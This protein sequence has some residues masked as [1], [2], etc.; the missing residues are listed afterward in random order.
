MKCGLI[1]ICSF[2][3]TCICCP[4]DMEITFLNKFCE[5]G[6]LKSLL[7]A[8]R[9]PSTIIPFV[10]QLRAY[11]N[12]IPFNPVTNHRQ[13]DASLDDQILE[14]L[15]H[16]MNRSFSIEHR[17]W[18][19]SHE[20][21]R[22]EVTDRVNYAPV[23]SRVTFLKDYAIGNQV[24]STSGV[25]DHNCMVSLKDNSKSSFGC[26]ESIFCHSRL[27]PCDK[28]SKDVFFT[29][30]PLST[31]PPVTSNPFRKLSS[32]EMHV[33]LWMFRPESSSIV[34][35]E[36]EILSHCAWI[37]FEPREISNEIDFSTIAVVMLDRS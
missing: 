17:A 10:Q 4:G 20:Y 7:E 21:S 13:F 36:S 8:Q 28:V 9:L 26:I 33:S 25:N 27:K 14:A 19:A 1:L 31:I 6:N 16:K 2:A 11:Y 30:K 32:F 18:I 37:E 3:S 5:V 12:P 24:Y 29:I 35:H 22:K 34:V 15:I 23:N